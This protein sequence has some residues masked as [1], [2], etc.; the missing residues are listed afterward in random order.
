MA[1]GHRDWNCRIG[2]AVVVEAAN[3][4]LAKSVQY[5]HGHVT[6]SWSSYWACGSKRWATVPSCGRWGMHM[7]SPRCDGGI[8]RWSAI[9]LCDGPCR[10]FLVQSDRDQIFTIST[11]MEGARQLAK[12][13]CSCARR[14]SVP[15][16]VGG[17]PRPLLAARPRLQRA[18]LSKPPPPSPSHINM[19]TP[20]R[21]TI[22]ATN[23]S[24]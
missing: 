3:A 23:P 1:W 14:R 18:T 17:T 24:P 22:Q 4:S 20:P 7:C 21:S 10:S 15:G 5:A 16:R 19:P 13:A 11:P 6:S 8:A 2:E 12:C 9:M